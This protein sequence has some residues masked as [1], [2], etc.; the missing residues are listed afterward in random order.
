M[1]EEIKAGEKLL[2]LKQQDI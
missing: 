2:L 1:L